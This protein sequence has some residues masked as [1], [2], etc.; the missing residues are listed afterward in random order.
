[1]LVCLF[2][3]LF[4]DYADLMP[5]TSAMTACHASGPPCPCSRGAIILLF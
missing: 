2:V 3:V 1:M 5:N 4:N